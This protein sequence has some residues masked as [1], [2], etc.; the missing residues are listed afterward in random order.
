[1][2][3]EELVN[4]WWW[5]VGVL[6]GIMLLPILY[7]HVRAILSGIDGF[8]RSE[9]IV[10]KMERLVACATLAKKAETSAEYLF[11]WWNAAA[12]LACSVFFLLL[13]FKI[14]FVFM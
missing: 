5:R 10:G 9:E 2:F 8:L 13:F 3:S 11:F 4:L 6:A 14:I 12:S 7:V 1:M